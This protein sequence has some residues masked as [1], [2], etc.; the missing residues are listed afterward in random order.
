MSSTS[1]DGGMVA[2]SR[3]ILLCVSVIVSCMIA[4]YEYG[5]LFDRQ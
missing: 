3:K 5:L 4:S 2:E 1:V